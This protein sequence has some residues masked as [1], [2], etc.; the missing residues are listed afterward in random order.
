MA[1]KYRRALIRGKLERIPLH[2]CVFRPEL[3][4]EM[5]IRGDPRAR[6]AD[7]ACAP[8]SRL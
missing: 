2:A 6:K 8:V 1:A 5:P 7:D 4:P 3:F